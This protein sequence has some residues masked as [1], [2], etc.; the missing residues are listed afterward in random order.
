MSP[1]SNNTLRIALSPEQISCLR[2]GGW[3][4]PRII[5]RDIWSCSRTTENTPPWTPAVETLAQHLK[6]NTERATAS[7]VLSNR[8]CR[9]AW[10]PANPELKTPEEWLAYATHRMRAIYGD[11]AQNWELKISSTREGARLVNAVDR[12]LLEHLRTFCEEKRLTLASVQPYF[13]TAFNR[14][15]NALQKQS[16]WFVVEEE[17]HFTIA[18]F[19]RHAWKTLIT[20]RTPSSSAADLLNT[21]DRERRLIGLEDGTYTNVWLHSWRPQQFKLPQDARYQLH[22]VSSNPYRL[23]VAEGAAYAMAA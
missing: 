15:R 16:G 3:L 23:S 1:L 4:R 14:H 12:A 8:F 7:F 13:A 11:A 22:P 17:R 6:E 10:L 5:G 19:D 18:L 2:F 20:R 21:L 9:Y